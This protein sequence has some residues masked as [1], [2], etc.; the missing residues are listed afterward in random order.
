M[1]LAVQAKLHYN[2][3]QFTLVIIFPDAEFRRALSNIPTE[4][5]SHITCIIVDS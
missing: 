1:L 3:L 4:N 2:L 5:T